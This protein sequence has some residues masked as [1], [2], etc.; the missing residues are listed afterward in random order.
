MCDLREVLMLVTA[1]A[2][3]AE[4]LHRR[5]TRARRGSCVPSCGEIMPS[6]RSAGNAT[7][8]QSS[9]DL[10][11]VTPECWWS[12]IR[13][14][15]SIPLR[16]LSFFCCFFLNRNIAEAHMALRLMVALC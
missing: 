9:K 10:G 12:R 4:R 15:I 11:P 1:A 2:T 14:S 5:P 16:N 13:S 6:P 3:T 7:V 8:A